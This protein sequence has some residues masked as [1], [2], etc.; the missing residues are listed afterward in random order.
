MP[1]SN[2]TSDKAPAEQR[3]GAREH[4]KHIREEEEMSWFMR[5]MPRVTYERLRW[6]LERVQHDSL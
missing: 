2:L 6:S 3:A 5:L 4:L 1:S